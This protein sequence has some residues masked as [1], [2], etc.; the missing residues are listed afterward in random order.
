MPNITK[1]QRL[2]EITNKQDFYERKKYSRM[3]RVDVML[4]T[5]FPNY[6]LKTRV[7]DD[8]S[9]I[10]GS[11]A[12]L[13][14]RIADKSATGVEEWEEVYLKCI[15]IFFVC[16]LVLLRIHLVHCTAFWKL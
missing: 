1:E 8:V 3:F 9:M 15:V 2:I 5:P 7:K 14:K 10:Q 4:V 11:T 12:I 13:R 6:E 16:R